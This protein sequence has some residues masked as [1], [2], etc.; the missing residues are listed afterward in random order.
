MLVKINGD[1]YAYL[2]TLL[3]NVHVKEL[4]LANMITLVTL[5]VSNIKFLKIRLVILV[6]QIV[7]L[8][9]L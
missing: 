3:M 8:Y 4:L 6:L 7:I 5:P 2:L 1:Q 9:I